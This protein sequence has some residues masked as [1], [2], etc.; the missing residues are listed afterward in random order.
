M[1][2][3]RNNP[4]QNPGGNSNNP[5][6]KGEKKGR[7]LLLPLLISLAMLLVFMLI[8]D[9]VAGSKYQ[10]VTYT[11]FLRAKEAGELGAMV[12]EQVTMV[13]KRRIETEA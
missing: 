6:S 2:D 9:A 5:N 13:A 4:G 1:D 11:E 3:K 7:G 12:L 8:Y 10:E